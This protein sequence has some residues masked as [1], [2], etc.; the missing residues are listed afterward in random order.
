MLAVPVTEDLVAA[1]LGEV[2][3]A[4]AGKQRT[5]DHH[6]AAQGGAFADELLAFDVGRV[7]VRGAEAVF[8][9]G[10]ALD[11]HAHA[12]EEGDEILDVEDFGDVGDG[13]GLG[14]EQDGTDDFQRFVL[15]ALGR[16]A[17]AQGM[18]S[19][20]DE[21]TH[22]GLYVFDFREEFDA[23]LLPDAVDDFAF[24]GEDIFGAGGAGGVDDDEG[25]ALVDG[26]FA[27]LQTLQAALVDQ[28]CRRDLDL[29][30]TEIIM[31]YRRGFRSAAAR[32]GK[33]N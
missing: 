19:F 2:G 8:A 17:A 9:F 24:E 33:Q 31:R 18:A 14:A 26:R 10:E 27:Q 13:N 30:G 11:L 15:G 7:D 28:P 32:F 5:D 3:P 12:L 21:C 25:L 16:D 4:E 29:V 22:M 23:E 1:R 20:Y 6:G